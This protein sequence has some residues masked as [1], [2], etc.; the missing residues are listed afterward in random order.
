MPR[1][2][3]SAFDAN[4]PLMPLD[5]ALTLLKARALPV[6]G[7]EA[8]PL[9]AALR[10]VL[11]EDLVAGMNVPPADNAAVDGYAV[12]HAD[13]IEGRETRLPLA[14]RIPAGPAWTSP[15]LTGKAYRIFTG[16]VLPQGL[17]TVIMQE[18]VRAEAKGTVVLPAGVRP[19]ANR[20]LAGEDIRAGATVIAKG[21]RLRPQEIA[22]AA[23]LG[24]SELAVYRPL[25]AA[26]FSTGDEIR[27]PGAALDSGA[28]FDAN[29]FSI[30]ATLGA[31]GCAVTDLGILPD[32][33]ETIRRALEGAAA[34]HDVIVTSG[35]VSVGEEDHVKG[36]VKALGS[37]DL[38]RL[39]IK[40]GRPIAL[41]RI[42][43]AA[44]IGLP[45]N[46]VAALVTCLRIARPLIL[47]MSGR[48]ATAPRLY[49]VRAAFDFRK[50]PGRREWVRAH[51][52]SGADGVPVAHKF[53]AEG[54]AVLSSMVAADGLIELPEGCE[55]VAPGNLVPFLPFSEVLG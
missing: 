22:I 10:R 40:P 25:K 34:G 23:A 44:F 12:R 16:A 35:G 32:D 18:D 27:E 36:A 7:A 8:V 17:D 50:K 41:G 37:L 33:P 6:A 54:S 13:L 55:R 31:F 51:L 24:R 39:A 43:K 38:W 19:G 49:M 52:E 42:G 29:R 47:G 4:G 53:A 46:P 1:S 11:A 30:A 5:E 26:I 20:R 14:G 15:V 2:D 9:R 28:I 45:G 21:R 3:A 48:T